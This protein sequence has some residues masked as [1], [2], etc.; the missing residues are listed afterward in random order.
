MK[1][2]AKQVYNTI[3]TTYIR[4][5]RYRKYHYPRRVLSRAAKHRHAPG[6]VHIPLTCSNQN[7]SC[8]V[9]VKGS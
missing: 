1:S 5:K 3:T 9:R 4:G 7:L 8:S 2:K 6:A